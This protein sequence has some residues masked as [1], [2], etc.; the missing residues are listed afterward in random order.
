MVLKK[1]CIFLMFCVL[2]ALLVGQEL[3]VERGHYLKKTYQVIK[4]L[5][6]AERDS[7]LYAVELIKLACLCCENGYSVHGYL[8][9]ERAFIYLVSELERENPRIVPLAA[10]TLAQLAALSD[11]HK[12]T[13]AEKIDMYYRYA[14]H[15]LKGFEHRGV[16]HQYIDALVYGMRFYAKQGNEE[17]VKECYTEMLATRKRW[18]NITDKSL[19]YFS[20][21]VA[22]YYIQHSKISEAEKVLSVLPSAPNRF[23]E[24]TTLNNLANIALCKREY[25]KAAD[26]LDRAV[27]GYYYHKNAVSA[28]I[29]TTCPP[30]FLPEL[31]YTA[32]LYNSVGFKKEALKIYKALQDL[33]L[34]SLESYIPYMLEADR[35]HLW[36]M[37]ADYF[38]EMQT[39]AIKN[40]DLEGI[41]AFLYGN[42][43]L[44]KNIFLSPPRPRPID[45][46]IFQTDPYVKDLSDKLN[47]YITSE[48]KSR[49]QLTSDIVEIAKNEML[50]V[51]YEREMRSYMTEI[52]QLRLFKLKGWA[53]IQKMMNSNDAVLDFVELQESPDFPKTYGVIL[54][55]KDSKQ[56]EFIHLCSHKQLEHA[57]NHKHRDELLVSLLWSRMSEWLCDVNTLFFSPTGLINTIPFGGLKSDGSYLCERFDIHYQMNIETL[58]IVNSEKGKMRMDQSPKG[59]YLFGGADFGLVVHEMDDVRSQGFG[60]LPGSKDEVN[61]IF[62]LVKAPWKTYKFM[63]KDA[64]EKNLRALSQN[65]D[66]SVLHISTHGFY[67]PFDRG[68]ETPGINNN[69]KSGHFEPLLRTGLM[70]SGANYAWKDSMNNDFQNDCIV[71]AM[72]L[73]NM[74]FSKAEL[75]VF[76]A[77]NTGLGG[78]KDGEGVAGIQK[79]LRLSGVRSII[80]SLNDVPDK[81]T[82]E[83]MTGF[84]TYWQDGYCKSDAFIRAQRDM[85]DKYPDNPEKWA[86]FILME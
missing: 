75:A 27:S 73:S 70:L 63:G 45:L 80:L 53:D 58:D 1:W 48:I 21:E 79:A 57:L 15:T 5:E 77:C 85:K 3:D 25:A 71:T 69:G 49:T 50:G 2:S 37:M 17:M 22:A 36:K 20:N 32:K 10:H 26:L 86:G 82:A 24:A 64:T 29:G 52:Q 28:M 31:S 8:V 7:T 35:V 72:D 46:D 9:M 43:R 66:V 54:L 65:P 83:L 40:T 18:E 39:F 4:K 30:T 44:K 41:A 78:I 55:K 59:I 61:A 6:A 56:P 47:A 51:A 12:T 42:N 34:S 13:P 67:L 19:F 38:N 23:L 68:I 84:Y 14:I 62:Q 74:I 81:E 16:A 60:Y 33:L 76:S 11:F